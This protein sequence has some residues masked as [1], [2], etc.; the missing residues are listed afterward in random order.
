MSD[1][2][3]IDYIWQKGAELYRPMP[4]R[5][6]TRPYYVLVS[7]LMLQQTQ[8]PRVIPKFTAFVAAFPDEFAL[9]QASLADVLVLWQGLGYNRRAK[10]LHEAAKQIVPRGAFPDSEADLLALPGVGKN[11]AA[12]IMAYSFNHPSVFVETNIRTVYLHHFFADEDEVDDKEI[13]Q[14]L[15]ATI[16]REHPREFYWALMDYGASLKNQGVRNIRQSRHYRKQSPLAGSLREMRGRII[17]VLAEG[18]TTVKNLMVRAE[19]D[20]RFEPA[21]DGLVSEGL[22]ERQGD[23]IG[24]TK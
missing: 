11:T 6:D 5:D 18:N 19:A 21:L 16:D 10:Y 23:H 14:K 4:W 3:F 24:L 7:E 22:V 12:A 9:A 20:E 2:D 8:V 1:S 17:K 13:I 15:S